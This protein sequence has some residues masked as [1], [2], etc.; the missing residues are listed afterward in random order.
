MSFTT[1][2]N[3]IDTLSS[4]GA[5]NLEASKAKMNA[6]AGSFRK[7]L[8]QVSLMRRDLAQKTE[9]ENKAE[10]KDG[11]KVVERLREVAQGFEAYFFQMLIKKMRGENTGNKLFENSQGHRMFTEMQDQTYSEEMSKRGMLGIADMVVDQFRSHAEG[12]AA[13]QEKLTGGKE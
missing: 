2:T 8:N 6:D 3:S 5:A 13:M 7:V 9:V 12:F 1:N 10:L 11:K 4:A